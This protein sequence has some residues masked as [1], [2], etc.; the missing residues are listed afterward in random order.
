MASSTASAGCE[1]FAPQSRIKFGSL[2]LLDTATS[3]PEVVIVGHQPSSTLDTNDDDPSRHLIEETRRPLSLGKL[4][5]RL[6][7]SS[8][9]YHESELFLCNRITLTCDP[10]DEVHLYKLGL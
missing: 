10:L 4:V 1:I 3:K 9:R 7:H 6:H 2:N 8:K 5:R